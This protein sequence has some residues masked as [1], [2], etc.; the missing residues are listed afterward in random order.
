M[1]GREEEGRGEMRQGT[2]LGVYLG[3]VRLGVYLGSVM[4]GEDLV[5]VQAQI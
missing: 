2:P 4:L 3:G 1:R 5:I